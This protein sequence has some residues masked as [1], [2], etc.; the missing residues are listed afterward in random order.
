MRILVV[1][2]ERDLAEAIARGLRRESMAVDVVL[3]GEAAVEKAT[4]E[5][6]DVIILDR[7]LP[8]L[9]GDDV[10]SQLRSAGVGSRVLMLTAS[11]SVDDRVR[12]LD[13]GADDYLGKPFDLGELKARV[14]ALARRQGRSKEP[15]LS[16]RG[17]LLDQG[18]RRVEREGRL[19]PLTRKE[20][21]ILEA[22][23]RADGAPVSSEEL[24]RSAWD[25][26]TNPFTNAVRITV[27][28]LRR[29]LGDPPV[30]ETVVG[31][32]YRIS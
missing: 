7:H 17:I 25:E 16:R 5:S 30:V 3:N 22:L 20:F 29:T 21:A 11:S 2:D 15:V 14:R 27:S 28:R 13:L 12:G 24:L 32:G 1:E 6:Y 4:V 31:V 9:H 18:T 8:G 26:E 10:C 23:M 19:V